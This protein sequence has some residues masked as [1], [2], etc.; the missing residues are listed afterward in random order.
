[1]GG[2]A[3]K[4]LRSWVFGATPGDR[5]SAGDDEEEAAPSRRG[6]A[7][8]WVLSRR[9]SLFVDE[10]GDLAN[11]FYEEIVIYINGR[12]T[13]SLRRILDNLRPQGRVKLKYPRIHADF[14]VVL[15]EV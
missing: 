3:S 14:P 13:A 4:T 5:G 15:C 7:S 8:P 11:E 6:L 9:G 1:M 2:D 10:D 12:Q